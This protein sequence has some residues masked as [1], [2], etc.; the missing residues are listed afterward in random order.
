MGTCHGISHLIW[1]ICLDQ[2]A[3]GKMT[4][5]TVGSFHGVRQKV[6]LAFYLPDKLMCS[7]A[8]AKFSVV[9]ADSNLH[10]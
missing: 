1:E 9:I 8:K 10:K 5:P 3:T 2:S 4:I 7:F 6:T